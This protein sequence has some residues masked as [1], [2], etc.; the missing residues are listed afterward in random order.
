MTRF[1]HVRLTCDSDT[2]LGAVILLRFKFLTE[3]SIQIV[4]LW[5]VTSSS[6][7]D[8]CQRFRGIGCIY[9]EGKRNL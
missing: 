4:L 9:L 8:G 1:G 2:Y 3:V 5:D 7:V 6:L